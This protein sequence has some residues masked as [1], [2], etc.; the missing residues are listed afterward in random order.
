[1][2]GGIIGS[3]LAAVIGGY[4]VFE[5]TTEETARIRERPSI[6]LQELTLEQFLRSRDSSE[7]EGYTADERSAVGN[8]FRLEISSSG[9][10]DDDLRLEWYLRDVDTD[11]LVTELALRRSRVPDASVSGGDT[12]ERVWIPLGPPDGCYAATF[13][14]AAED[15]I[16]DE[17]ESRRWC[18]SASFP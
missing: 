10:G 11:E 8:E 15:E 7:V 13:Q 14:L 1:V 4:I 2:G 12:T 17:A 16:K 6:A 9:Y 5:L 18:Q 3:V